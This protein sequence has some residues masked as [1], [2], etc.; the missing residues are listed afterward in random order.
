MTK[1]W[2]YLLCG[3]SSESSTPTIGRVTE[4]LADLYQ[5]QAPG[6]AVGDDTRI[7]SVS[8]RSGHDQGP[9]YV[10]SITRPG[11]GTWEEWADQDY[12]AELCPARELALTE[13]QATKL[14]SHMVRG[15]IDLVRTAFADAVER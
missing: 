12:E 4:A 14:L 9:M 6:T 8:L 1:A 13:A 10:L 7:D 11:I 3:S 5:E 15:N 2:T